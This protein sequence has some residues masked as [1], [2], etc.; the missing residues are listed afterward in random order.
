MDDRSEQVRLPLSR[1]LLVLVS[2]HGLNML[3]VLYSE[4]SG[5][6]NFFSRVE[7]SVQKQPC[8]WFYA[9]DAWLWCREHLHQQKGPEDS[10]SLTLL[11]FPLQGIFPAAYIH[12]KK[13]TVT[14]R[15]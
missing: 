7:S 2:E 11:S 15:G 10:F 14:N 8:W 5:L 6:E 12:L 1:T 9:D 3:L 4:I 13:A